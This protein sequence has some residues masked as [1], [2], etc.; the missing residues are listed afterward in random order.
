MTV[1]NGLISAAGTGLQKFVSAHITAPW[2]DHCT[3]SKNIKN[4]IQN[5]GFKV[6]G[7]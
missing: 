1:C 4:E 5:Q 7:I 6:S 3:T 2:Q